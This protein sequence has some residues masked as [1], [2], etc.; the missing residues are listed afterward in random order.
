MVGAVG[1]GGAVGAVGGAVA[2]A[3]GGTGTEPV[4]PG[5]LFDAVIGVEL[6]DVDD[7]AWCF[8]LTN[9]IAVAVT[10][11]TAT[12]AATAIVTSARR[13]GAR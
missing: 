12:A 13:R 2:V 1:A 3:S 5:W 10:T 7:T 11:S 6:V 8:G 9:Q 4:V